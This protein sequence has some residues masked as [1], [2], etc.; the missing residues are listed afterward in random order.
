MLFAV[1]WVVVRA[2]R[3]PS[4]DS[5][6]ELDDWDERVDALDKAVF[7]ELEAFLKANAASPALE[8]PLGGPDRPRWAQL[9]DGLAVAPHPRA[10]PG[11]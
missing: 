8:S 4:P 7:D 9:A 6:D 1:G 3:P 2:E 11:S 5:L 10:L